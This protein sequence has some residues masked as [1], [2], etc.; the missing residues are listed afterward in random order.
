MADCKIAYLTSQSGEPVFVAAGSVIGPAAFPVAALLLAVFVGDRFERV[1][2]FLSRPALRALLFAGR[3]S[4]IG[5]GPSRFVAAISRLAQT[6]F[7]VRTDCEQLLLA[8][9]P[10]FEPPEFATCWCDLNK[11][12]ATVPILKGLSRG[13]AFLI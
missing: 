4:A 1:A 5:Y 11:Q 8:V 10:V 7:G 3:I 2:G 12:S 6:Q 9:E 13:F